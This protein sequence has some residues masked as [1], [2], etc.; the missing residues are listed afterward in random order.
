MS[1]FAHVLGE[2]LHFYF[3]TFETPPWKDIF[4]GWSV[5]T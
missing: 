4:S 3:N 1:V 5:L 2:G